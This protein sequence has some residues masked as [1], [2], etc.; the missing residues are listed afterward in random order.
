MYK[1]QKIYLQ[2]MTIY[3]KIKLK[4]FIQKCKLTKTQK[5]T[6]FRF[7]FKRLK[8]TVKVSEFQ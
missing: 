1:N 2:E 3:D 5:I 6:S 4:R 8:F 7:N